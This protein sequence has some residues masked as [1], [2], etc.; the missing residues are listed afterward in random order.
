MPSLT[1]VGGGALGA[2]LASAL[3]RIFEITLI[4][5]SSHFV[6]APAMIRAVVEPDILD[7][8]LIPYDN[9][10]KRGQWVRRRAVKVAQN[11]IELDDG[12]TQSSDFAVIATGSHYAAPFKSSN[13]P[14]ELREEVGLAHAA[15]SPAHTIAI[16]GAGAVGVE[17]AGEI[18]TAFPEKR[19]TLITDQETLFPEFPEKFAAL[20]TKDLEALGVRVELGQAVVNLAD[21][22]RP[23]FGSVALQDGRTIDADLIFPAIGS[24]P[25]SDLLQ[26]IGGMQLNEEGRATVDPWLRVAGCSYPVFAAGDAAATGDGMT[27]VAAQRQSEW[28]AKTL[29]KLAK[30]SSIENLPAYKPWPRS[31]IVLP[32]GPERGASFLP[33]LTLGSWVT[34]KLKGQNL[35]L[36][37]YNKLLGRDY[38]G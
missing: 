1:I 8:A 3:D 26:S 11:G 31:P 13:D 36:P 10:L 16:V 28:L 12:Q 27:V 22:S 29:K 4:E 25:Q 32:L 37:K 20:V 19:V 34:S 15:L 17:L 5:P 24:R 30:G 7:A 23:S 33:P 38:S 21:V 2:N 35:F 6:H 18:A 14:E 9:L